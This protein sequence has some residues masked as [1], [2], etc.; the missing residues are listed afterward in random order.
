M[1][2]PPEAI[3][4]AK[5]NPSGWVYAIEGDYGPDESVPPQTIRGA[6]K[7]DENG[8]ITGEFIPNP[9]FIAG[10]PKPTS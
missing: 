8:K 2:P 5:Q 10:F 3:A 7:V 1:E 4:E 6:W 9:N